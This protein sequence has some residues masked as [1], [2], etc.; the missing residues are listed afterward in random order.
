MLPGAATYLRPAALLTPGDLHVTNLSAGSG[1]S[2]PTFQYVSLVETAN[3]DITMAMNQTSP[4][5]MVTGLFHDRDS[6]ER[7]YSDISARGL[8]QG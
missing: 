7:A 3:E 8:W 2:G 6:A 4:S 1:P 5:R